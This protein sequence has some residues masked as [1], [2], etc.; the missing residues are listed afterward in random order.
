ML[1]L[2]GCSI[3]PHQGLLLSLKYCHPATQRKYCEKVENNSNDQARQ[4]IA[5]EVLE[6]GEML[7]DTAIDVAT[8]QP[9]NSEGT[10]ASNVEEMRV[11]ADEFF[12]AL[13]SLLG[14]EQQ[15]PPVEISALASLIP[16]DHDKDK[17]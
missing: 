16:V 8:R 1:R 5:V 9:A 11:A 4:E 14:T 10:D 17:S 12:T 6:L 3:L 13:R 2:Q 15:S 7:F